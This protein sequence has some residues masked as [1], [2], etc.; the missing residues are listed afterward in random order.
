MMLD[1]TILNLESSIKKLLSKKTWLSSSKPTA[2][3]IIVLWA[4]SAVEYAFSLSASLFQ[5]NKC[6][7]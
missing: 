2:E 1:L 3:R 6:A 4:S 5:I 7:A